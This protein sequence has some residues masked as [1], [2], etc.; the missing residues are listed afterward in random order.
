EG[1]HVDRADTRVDADVETEIDAVHAFDGD[2][3]RRV[4]DVVTGEREHGAVVIGV[5][6]DVQHVVAAG[7]CDRF[8]QGAVSTLADVD[9]ALEHALTVP[10][11]GR[12]HRPP[13]VR[14]LDTG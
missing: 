7:A 13:A 3:T 1:N 2:G 12:R 8:D 10:R 9:H 6:V 14:L 11:G 5:S 4:F